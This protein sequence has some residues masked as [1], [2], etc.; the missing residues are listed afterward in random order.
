MIPG[1]LAEGIPD[2][3]FDPEQLAMGIEVELEHTND[4]RLAEEI[5]RDHLAEQI[6]KGLPQDYY[7]RL[8]EMEREMESSRPKG[9]RGDMR[10]NKQ[11]T[12]AYKNRLP[13]SAFLWVGPGGE[14]DE[15][16]R[17]HPLH[18]RSLPYKDAQGRV[19]LPH[20]RNAIARLPVTR[21]IPE[22]EKPRLKKRACQILERH[23]GECSTVAY[24][25]NPGEEDW[26]PAW[27]EDE[28]QKAYREAREAGES[29]K[30]AKRY[31][32]MCLAELETE[33]YSRADVLPPGYESEG[34]GPYRRNRGDEDLLRDVRLEALTGRVFRLQTYDTGR[35]DRRGVPY[36]AYVFSQVTPAEEA[37]VI[38]EGED[39]SCS[40]MHA[41]DS[42][43]CVRGLLGFLTLRPGDTD[44]DY[45]DDYTP[46]QMTFADQDAESLSLYS[47]ESGDYGDE[48]EE[49]PLEEWREDEF[50][51]NG[52]GRNPR[53]RRRAHPFGPLEERLAEGPP[54]F[55]P[56][57]V[58]HEPPP[59][60]D[61]VAHMEEELVR[62]YMRRGLSREEAERKMRKDYRRNPFGRALRRQLGIEIITS[63]NRPA[64]GE[65]MYEVGL[66]W[67]EGRRPD[68]PRML[69]S[70]AEDM[71]RMTE[72]ARAEEIEIL[73]EAIALA[74]A[75]MRA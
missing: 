36:T 19:D 37:G 2:R 60:I 6:R 75:D 17:T 47:M 55:G 40:P 9:S 12:T 8:A 1:G 16:N 70:A 68:D 64:P 29:H 27:M 74:E 59:G 28:W 54:G 20:L 63:Y 4:R 13:D 73:E 21:D 26:P 72:G 10:E 41:V 14:K 46:R 61:P 23:G 31:A 3:A 71:E 11:W 56:Y 25:H 66:A 45:F 7:T 18:L 15:Q 69:E 22:S 32:D 62:M 39:F 50:P 35:Y 34:M 53:R 67:S 65:P 33:A 57:P 51:M 30:V 24:Q 5:A 38:F 49:E 48:F 52:M 43:E 42:D 58:V 44:Q